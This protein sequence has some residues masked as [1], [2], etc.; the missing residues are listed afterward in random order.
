ME[1]RLGWVTAV[2]AY[3]AIETG[4]R[5]RVWRVCE[6][7]PWW[8]LL[9]GYPHLWEVVSDFESLA[10]LGVVC[11]LFP[12]PVKLSLFDQQVSLLY[13]FCLLCATERGEVSEQ[14]C[15]C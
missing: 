15:G 9:E 5:R 8:F 11:P 1:K 7:F 13:S 3:L 4:G 12:S 2:T 6:C 14:Q 10:A